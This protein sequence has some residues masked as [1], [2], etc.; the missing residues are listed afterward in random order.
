[1]EIAPPIFLQSQV[2]KFTVQKS[3]KYLGVRLVSPATYVAYH[4]R[5]RES[6]QSLCIVNFT[7]IL[8]N[9]KQISSDFKAKFYSVTIKPNWHPALEYSHFEKL[10]RFLA[11]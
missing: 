11:Y 8:T 10:E 9:G 4:N 7:I 5:K 6:K 2:K 1:M 3:A